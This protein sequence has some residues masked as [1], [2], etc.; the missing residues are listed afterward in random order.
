MQLKKQNPD[1]GRLFISFMRGFNKDI[2]KNILF[3]WIRSLIRFTYHKCPQQIIQLTAAKIREVRV[4]ATS[5]VWKVNTALP[6]FL[7]TACWFHQ[8]TFTS[9]YLKDIS[10]I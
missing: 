9:Y 3:E 10:V 2:S 5:M 1:A 6:N 7:Q 4:L 8:N